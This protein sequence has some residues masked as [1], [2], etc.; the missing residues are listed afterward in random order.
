MRSEQ[1]ARR[2]APNDSDVHTSRSRIP[3]LL[4]HVPPTSPVGHPYPTRSNFYPITIPLFPHFA[5]PRAISLLG[6]TFQYFRTLRI[7]G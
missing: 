6:L 7:G 2:S 1:G 4:Q 5:I 3:G